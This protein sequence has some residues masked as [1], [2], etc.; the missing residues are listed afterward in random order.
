MINPLR[1]KR[2]A[3]R[4]TFRGKQAERVLRDLAKFCRASAST[5]EDDA[6]KHA[7]REGRREVWLRIQ[8]MLNLP[9]SRVQELSEVIPNE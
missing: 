6:R 7:F 5:Y 1:I 8:A 3:Y 2:D 4:E 9:D